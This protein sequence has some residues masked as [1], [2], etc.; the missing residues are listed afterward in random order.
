MSGQNRITR[1]VSNGKSLFPDASNLVGA[2]STY[3]QGDLLIRDSG[4]K[5]LRAFVTGDTEAAAGPLFCGIA[6]QTIK[7]GKLAYPYVT[8]VDASAGLSAVQGPAY[9]VVAHLGLNTGDTINPGDKVYLIPG[10]GAASAYTVTTSAG[11]HEVGV[12]QGPAIAGAP[13]GTFIDVLVGVRY[14]NDT[15]KF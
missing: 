11:A 7:N 13:A 9:D 14:P 8:D 6:T 15:L 1:S 12:Y 3:N 10:L 5:L 2:A 4:T